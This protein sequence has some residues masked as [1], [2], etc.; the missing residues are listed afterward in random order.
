[1]ADVLRIAL[2]GAGGRI[3]A[4][5]RRALA[6]SADVQTVA[7][8]E[9]DA[10]A[11]TCLASEGVAALE[12]ISELRGAWEVDAAILATPPST[13]EPLTLELLDSGMHVICEKPLALHSASAN[14]MVSR[15]T[16]CERVLMMASKFRFVDDVGEASRRITA[17]DIGEPVLYEN[18]FCSV[19]D[20]RGR[21]NAMASLSGGGVLIDNGAHAADLARVLVGPI[22]RVFAVAGPRV[23]DVPVEDSARITFE[24][25]SGC[26]GVATLSWSVLTGDPAYA[27]VHG[28]EGSIELG[29]RGSRIRSRGTGAWQEFGGGYDKLA[30]FRAQLAHF[31]SAVRGETTPLPGHNDALDSVRFVTAAQTSLREARWV[32]LHAGSAV[33][34]DA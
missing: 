7:C 13:H 23:Q 4:D 30:A 34:P 16:D 18:T 24:T 3:A 17:G 6:T 14:R 8:V 25:T 10:A 26:V 32:E 20:M 22:V 28:S 1:M 5:W 19:V 12:S 27:R 21:W 15:A 31:V 2:V 33:T 29:W 11:R 9:T